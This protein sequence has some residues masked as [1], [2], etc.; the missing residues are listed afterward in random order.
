MSRLDPMTTT[1]GRL[2]RITGTVVRGAITINRQ[3]DWVEVGQIVW[4]GMIAP[5]PRQG[6]AGCRCYWRTSYLSVDRGPGTCPLAGL[7]VTARCAAL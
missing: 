2:G 4:H 1:A 3:I 7:G 6:T 5:T